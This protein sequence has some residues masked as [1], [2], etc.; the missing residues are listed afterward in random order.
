MSNS[1]ARADMR[2]PG[3]TGYLDLDP[4]LPYQ[5]LRGAASTPELASGPCQ[6]L[7][8]APAQQAMTGTKYARGATILPH[9]FCL[10]IGTTVGPGAA[11]RRIVRNSVG[12]DRAWAG[13]LGARLSTL[14]STFEVVAIHAGGGN[15][16]TVVT[17]HQGFPLLNIAEE[18]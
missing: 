15:R 9:I 8:I 18:V 11:R 16:P 1:S 2:K 4:R 6:P 10:F 17:E 5:S 3:S 13:G 14:R 12:P 7:P